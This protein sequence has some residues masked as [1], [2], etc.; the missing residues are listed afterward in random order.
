MQ[1]D[2]DTAREPEF[3][4][5]VQMHEFLED[6]AQHMRDEARIAQEAAQRL[7]PQR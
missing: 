7:D 6:L 3:L 2:D 1:D 4:A 5:W